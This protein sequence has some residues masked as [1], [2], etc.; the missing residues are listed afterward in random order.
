MRIRAVAVSVPPSGA[1]GPWE[2][3]PAGPWVQ[4]RVGCTGCAP[5]S[6]LA[7]AFTLLP[8]AEVLL[9]LRVEGWLGLLPTVGLVVA[10]G[11]GGAW[12]ARRQGL[13]V[14]ARLRA[15]VARGAPPGG[16]LV[17]GALLL[18]A[19]CLLVTPG[20]LTDAV[21]FLLLLPPFRRALV[22]GLR[23]RVFGVPSDVP[24]VEGTAWGPG[25]VVDAEVLS[26]RAAPPPASDDPDALSSTP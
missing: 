24:S 13:A 20:L 9:L 11:L 2:P 14:L 8:L 26:S 1:E 17:E 21:G 18:V 7:L 10:T 3:G 23:R 25:E 22:R 19:G 16:P 5:L 12:L 15:E 4:G 6:A